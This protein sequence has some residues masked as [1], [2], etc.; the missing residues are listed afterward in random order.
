MF[1]ANAVH[2][3]PEYWEDEEQ[4]RADLEL[5]ATGN[6]KVET[7]LALVRAQ[8]ALVQR[9]LEG[10]LDRSDDAGVQAALVEVGLHEEEED[11]MFKGID[12]NREQKRLEKA[13]GKQVG[14][15]KAGRLAANEQEWESVVED[16]HR[17]ARPHFVTGPPG[18]GKSTV[19]DKMVRKCLR[20]GGRVLYALY[21]RRSRRREREQ[22]TLRPMLTHAREPFSFTRMPLK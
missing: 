12:L 8:R 4:L 13:L 22:S 21:P 9:F 11:P 18:T 19:V 15:A 17:N 1:F 5:E 2:Q 6:D 10:D 7:F 3:C 20:G 14:R 16:A